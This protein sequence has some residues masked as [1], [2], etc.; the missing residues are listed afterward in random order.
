VSPYLKAAVCHLSLILQAYYKYITI[1]CQLLT[2]K[3]DGA[4]IS[5]ECGRS[6][7][8]SCILKANHRSLTQKQEGNRWTGEVV[9][10]YYALQDKFPSKIKI[11]KEEKKA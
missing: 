10:K 6:M 4:I 11:Q 8:L 3:I 2:L 7:Y 9:H 5:I 1:S